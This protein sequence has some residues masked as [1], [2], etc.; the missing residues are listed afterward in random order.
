LS[1]QANADS[2]CDFA[3]VAAACARVQNVLVRSW[4]NRKAAEV[5]GWSPRY[6]LEEI[7]ATAWQWHR[8]HPDG[9]AATS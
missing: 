2:F 8:K 4:D 3:R 7:I 5:L 9:F 1:E 6:G